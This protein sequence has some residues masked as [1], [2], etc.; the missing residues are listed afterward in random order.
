MSETFS[1]HSEYG[2]DDGDFMNS[3]K[4]YF[5]RPPLLKTNGNLKAMKNCKISATDDS[6]K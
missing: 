4:S 2:A 6:S 3:D 5:V 1:L